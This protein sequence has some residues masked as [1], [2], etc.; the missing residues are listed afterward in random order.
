MTSSAKTS[1]IVLTIL[2]AVI[3]G[4]LV[5]AAAGLAQNMFGWRSGGVVPGV[6][7]VIG[8]GAAMFY[9]SRQRQRAARIES[10]VQG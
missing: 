9:R 2:I 4:G 6:A 8:A 1:D 5:G 10:Q 7:G 3:A